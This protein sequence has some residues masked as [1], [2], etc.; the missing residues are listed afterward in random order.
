MTGFNGDMAFFRRWAILCERPP[1]R[2]PRLKIPPFR[3]PLLGPAPRVRRPPAQT[4]P[5]L[6][7]S[8]DSSR[9]RHR[10]TFFLRP[11]RA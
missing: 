4:R 6:A 1:G 5:R 2:A 3:G 10:K 8:R 9:L 7:E 11:S